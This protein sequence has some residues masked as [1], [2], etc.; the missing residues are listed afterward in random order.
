MVRLRTEF[1]DDETKK[2]KV[3]RPWLFRQHKFGNMAASLNNPERV[4]LLPHQLRY[5]RYMIV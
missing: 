5:D 2:A 4:N 1:D 3:S